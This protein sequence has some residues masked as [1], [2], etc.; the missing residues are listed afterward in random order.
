MA[1]KLRNID[2]LKAHLEAL[3]RQTRGE[4]RRQR[5]QQ[6]LAWASERILDEWVRTFSLMSRYGQTS[7]G[8]SLEIYTDGD[9]ALVA[10][11]EAIEQAKRRIW[12]ETYIIQ[13]DKVGRRT[14]ELL[15]AA[16]SRGREVILVYDAFGSSTF[17]EEAAE[18][19][20]AAGGTTV[21]Y[22]PLG[23][24]RKPLRRTHRKLLTVDDEIGFCGGMNLSE[25]YGSSC[26][27]NGCFRDCHMRVSGPAVADMVKL[28]AHALAEMNVNPRRRARSA[29]ECGD[30]IVQMLE[31]DGWFARNDIQRVLRLTV[32]RA[33][34]RCWIMTP[35]F[36]PQEQLLHAFI[37]AAR[38]GVDMRVMTAGKSDVPMMARASKHVYPRLLKHGVKVY[39]MY[40]QTLHAKTAT[41]D[42][43]FAMVGS[44]NLDQWSAKRNLEVKAAMLDPRVATRLEAAFEESL[45]CCREVTLATL[46]RRSVIEKFRHWVAYLLMRI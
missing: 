31:S 23:W 29:P 19:L 43:I 42:G 3:W 16:A 46:E 24:S 36:L 26:W 15:T 13:D 41:M 18:P 17:P 11:W 6:R 40:E 7:A 5:R 30:S 45:S 33:V 37:G 1:S 44:Y 2:S 20:R 32:H 22:N 34:K 9:D 28:Q 39:E 27:G 25:D 4:F 8:N 35:Y 10:M 12:V 38:R 14:I 21:R